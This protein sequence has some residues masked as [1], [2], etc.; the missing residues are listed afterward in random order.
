MVGANPL[1]QGQRR[2]V[3]QLADGRG[4]GAG[5]LGKLAAA[6]DG[7]EFAGELAGADDGPYLKYLRA[8]RDWD[9][10]FPGFSHDTHGVEVGE[11]GEQFIQCLRS[12]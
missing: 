12:R 9:Q 5:W 4:D 1:E 2:V 6:R 11:D 3:V 10:R 7:F 8:L